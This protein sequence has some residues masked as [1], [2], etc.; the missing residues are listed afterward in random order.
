[1]GPSEKVVMISKFKSVG[2]LNYSWSINVPICAKCYNS[3]QRPAEI[4]GLIV[5]ALGIAVGVLIGI[6]TSSHHDRVLGIIMGGVL[7]FFA[8]GVIGALIYSAVAPARLDIRWRDGQYIL[9]GVRFQNKEY[10]ELFDQANH[11]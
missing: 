7:G 1:M 10:Q 11:G 8:G 5:V 9:E 3:Y 2:T 6:L 4:T